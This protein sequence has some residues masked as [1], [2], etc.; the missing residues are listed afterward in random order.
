MNFSCTTTKTVSTL[1][2]NLFI[3]NPVSC[4]TQSPETNVSQVSLNRRHVQTEHFFVLELY[5]CLG[6]IFYFADLLRFR[7]KTHLVGLG[8]HQV[9][10]PLTSMV[11]DTTRMDLN[12]SR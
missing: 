1:A 3:E 8:K 5:V 2:D 4:T 10:L 7:H 6:R 9:R 11:F 12:V